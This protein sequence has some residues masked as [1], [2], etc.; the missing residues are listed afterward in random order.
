MSGTDFLRNFTS[1]IKGR[2]DD[3]EL[4][5]AINHLESLLADPEMLNL[6][7]QY[8]EALS[9]ASGSK[10]Q[11][12]TDHRVL[13]TRAQY[14]ACIKKGLS[15]AVKS[16]DVG[17]DQLMMMA[18]DVEALRTF[19]DTLIEVDSEERADCW[20]GILSAQLPVDSVDVRSMLPDDPE[21]GMT[22]GIE[23]MIAAW[24]G[25]EARLEAE[26]GMKF[27]ESGTASAESD[28]SLDNKIHQRAKLI[29]DLY[30]MESLCESIG[31]AN[32]RLPFDGLKE[33]ALTKV[34]WRQFLK[35]GARKI[36]ESL[37]DVE[38]EA[39]TD[40]I[41]ENDYG[42]TESRSEYLLLKLLVA[43]IDLD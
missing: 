16:G 28:V 37:G 43:Y 24:I 8:L 38:I 12:Q 9:E 3:E 39:L 13:L 32:F 36:R 29:R 1:Y 25:S 42:H 33:L 21:I 10:R 11:E 17:F 41:K 31:P 18:H 19:I 20:K 30:G 5:R 15:E 27:R 4:A 2:T 7:I 14:A 34:T 23:S 35:S 22:Q 40:W 6:R 26:P